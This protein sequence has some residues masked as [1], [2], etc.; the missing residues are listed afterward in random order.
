M[1]EKID[2]EFASKVDFSQ[3]KDLFHRY[4]FCCSAQNIFHLTDYVSAISSGLQ[5]LVS[6]LESGCDTTL[7]AMTKVAKATSAVHL[8]LYCICTGCMAEHRGGGRSEQLC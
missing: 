8:L 1:K 7:V 5:L 3:E 2:E 6:N 4:I